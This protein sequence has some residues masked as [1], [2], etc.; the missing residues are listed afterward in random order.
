MR[1]E[2]KAHVFGDRRGPPDTRPPPPAFLSSPAKKNIC[3]YPQRRSAAPIIAR[4]GL[5]RELA[6][7]SHKLVVDAAQQDRMQV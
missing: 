1:I 3:R 2:F 6:P 5:N 4:Q 7:E